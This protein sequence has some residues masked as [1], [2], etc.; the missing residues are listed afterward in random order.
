MSPIAGSA[1]A[2]SESSCTDSIS[3]RSTGTVI[4][5]PTRDNRSAR[6]GQGV[7]HCTHARRVVKAVG[8]IEEESGGPCD[9]LGCAWCGPR[10]AASQTDD[11]ILG[12]RWAGYFDA[13]LLIHTVP[14]EVSSSSRHDDVTKH[15]GLA[16]VVAQEGQP[17]VLLSTW[18]RPSWRAVPFE[19]YFGPL[20]SE[21]AALLR[22]RPVWSTKHQVGE[23]RRLAPGQN[24]SKAIA[25]AKAAGMTNR[26]AA[27]VLAAGREAR[28]AAD[29]GIV[30]LVPEDHPHRGASPESG[31]DREPRE[32]AADEGV[33]LTQGE[34]GQLAERYRT[35]LRRWDNGRPRA[36]A[37]PTD[38][39]Q[40]AEY[41]R[42][43][44]GLQVCPTRQAKA[45]RWP[46][47][48]ELSRERKAA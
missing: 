6:F 34:L 46:V 33:R 17:D 24:W 20:E 29:S 14:A 11:L 40:L 4:E 19:E 13:Q 25:A 9:Q 39:G 36:W 2:S 43:R 23:D 1:S 44:G 22:A 32:L 18:A 47:L 5:F 48:D 45:A 10:V 7:G 37:L 30:P 16:V 21:L 42:V 12:L 28:A 15:G 38:P 3:T 41:L 35:V 26:P 8:G 31:L 27:V